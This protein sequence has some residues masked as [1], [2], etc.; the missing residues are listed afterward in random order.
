MVAALCDAAMVRARQP[1]VCLA[2]C[3]A[4]SSKWLTSGQEK[5]GLTWTDIS[6]YRLG[7]LQK[8]T[9]C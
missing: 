5:S 8:R 1:A 9:H 4:A 2:F 3:S 7:E 6:G